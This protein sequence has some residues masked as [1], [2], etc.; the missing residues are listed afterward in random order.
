MTMGKSI[1]IY[2]KN[3]SK[4]KSWLHYLMSFNAIIV[5]VLDIVQY[6]FESKAAD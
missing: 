6:I 2:G 4:K 5:Y 3:I 1:A